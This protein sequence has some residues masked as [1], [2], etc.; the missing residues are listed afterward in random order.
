LNTDQQQHPINW[1][2][3]RTRTQN[4]VRFLLLDIGT[5]TLELLL[6][7]NL[8]FIKVEEYIQETSRRNESRGSSV[9]VVS[10]C[11]LDDRAIEV[12]FPAEAKGFF[13]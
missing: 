6:K 8:T 11:A 3:H 5:E 4:S 10:H 7:P 2:C 9:S 1:L 13:L 12:G